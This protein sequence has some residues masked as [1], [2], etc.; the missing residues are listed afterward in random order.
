MILS[1]ANST[2]IH[3]FICEHIIWTHSLGSV[4]ETCFLSPTLLSTKIN[5]G[6]MS[7]FHVSGWGSCGLGSSSW[8]FSLFILADWFDRVVNWILEDWHVL[9]QMESWRWFD[10]ILGAYFRCRCGCL[11]DNKWDLRWRLKQICIQ[12]STLCFV[13][14]LWTWSCSGRIVCLH[15]PLWWWFQWMT[16][17][18][19]T[20]LSLIR[21]EFLYFTDTSEI[22]E[23]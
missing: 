14:I 21:H 9:T 16:L 23:I 20:L 7:R 1:L 11:R 5:R 3:E 19:S 18:S 13:N 2:R 22:M 12:I 15:Q 17:Y 8:C 4:Q 10:S 6:F